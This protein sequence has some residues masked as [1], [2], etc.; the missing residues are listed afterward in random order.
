MLGLY[1]REGRTRTLRE[2]EGR[3]GSGPPCAP[4]EPLDTSRESGAHG[5]RPAPDHDGRREDRA[6]RRYDADHHRKLPL[7][8]GERVLQRD[9]LPPGDRGFHDSGW[10]PAGYRTW[11][12][13]IHDQGRAPGEQPQREGHDLD[14][15]R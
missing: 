14:G 2:Q 1:D 9:P 7:T 12:T 15:E 3:R 13:W 8:R 10:G 5:N 11:R 6:P 4:G